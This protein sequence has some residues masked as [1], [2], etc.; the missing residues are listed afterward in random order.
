MTA[1]PAFIIRDP[2]SVRLAVTHNRAAVMH[3]FRPSRSRSRGNRPRPSA[4]LERECVTW[5]SENDFHLVPLRR[6]DATFRRSLSLRARFRS[7]RNAR[8]E[9]SLFRCGGIARANT[10][11]FTVPSKLHSRGSTG[12]RSF[13]RA[14]RGAEEGKFYTSLSARLPLFILLVQNRSRKIPSPL[15]ARVRP[16]KRWLPDK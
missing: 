4:R 10:R 14:Q 6:G 1:S 8:K 3:F 7:Q 15:F 11:L 9:I 12:A 13:C 5:F 2:I 16:I